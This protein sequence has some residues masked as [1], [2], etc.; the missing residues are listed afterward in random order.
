MV[1]TVCLG[2]IKLLH[3]HWRVRKSSKE[4]RENRCDHTMHRSMNTRTSRSNVQGRND[5]PFGIRAIESGIEVDGVWISRGNSP[6]PADTDLSITPSVFDP[7]THEDSGLRFKDQ[8]ASSEIAR[9]CTH[10]AVGYREVHRRSQML[11]HGDQKQP[12]ASLSGRQFSLVPNAKD[13][14][15]PYF[16]S[17]SASPTEL[18]SL[19]TLYR[20]PVSLPNDYQSPNS[21]WPNHSL[22]GRGGPDKALPSAFSLPGQQG[23]P[24]PRQQSSKDLDLL[25]SHRV[26]Q[27]A[28]TGQFTPRGGRPGQSHSA[29]FTPSSRPPGEPIVFESALDT[30]PVH[31]QSG[32]ESGTSANLDLTAKVE[33]LPPAFRRS[34]L[35]DLTPFTEFCKRIS[36]DARPGSSRS[37][38]RDST[39]SE[40]SKSESP[41]DSTTSSPIIA[42]SE[43]AAEL[44]LPLGQRPSF[45]ERVSQ[46]LRGQ[47]SGFEILKPGSFDWTSPSQRPS[48]APPVSLCNGSRARSGCDD[49]RNRLRKKRQPSV[50]TTASS[51]ASRRS[52]MTLFG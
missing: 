9:A 2:C 22:V 16:T 36:Q 24:Q 47:G 5:I 51:V 20:A 41:V 1:L 50:E 46:V 19:D 17:Q 12:A 33:A 52:R 7:A 3:I 38:S 27:A 49:E 26:F 13:G 34:S 18:T 45:E 21:G 11:H 44:K 23:M 32:S 25:N 35:P 30:R 48:A 40:A 8:V 29:D 42:A 14:M 37:R 15:P 10:S 39:Q 43:G 28:E 6:E 31:R 4:D